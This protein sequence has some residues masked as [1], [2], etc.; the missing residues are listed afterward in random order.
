[1]LSKWKSGLQRVR[2]MNI[3]PR[4][5]HSWQYNDII[6]R[7]NNIIDLLIISYSLK[8][9]ALHELMMHSIWLFFSGKMWSISSSSSPASSYHEGLAKNPT[10]FVEF[11]PKKVGNF[12]NLKM[13][14]F[15]A[16]FPN[17]WWNSHENPNNLWHPFSLLLSFFFFFSYSSFASFSSPKGEEVVYMS[18]IHNFPK[19][20]GKF[21]Y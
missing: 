10:I 6:L 19:K 9:Q 11:F 14:E 8:F 15:S 21:L 1:M 2:I 4:F 18:K 7:I 12:G 3:L 16:K 20:I 13:A 5:T 17:K